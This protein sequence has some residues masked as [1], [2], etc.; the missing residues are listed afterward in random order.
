MKCAV[1]GMFIESRCVLPAYPSTLS[2]MRRATSW[3]TGI[4]SG[5][6]SPEPCFAVIFLPNIPRL[7]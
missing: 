6:G 4:Q 2:A 5:F 7:R 3:A 1:S